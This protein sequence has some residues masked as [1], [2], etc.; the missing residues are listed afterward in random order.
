MQRWLDED[1]PTP[2]IPPSIKNEPTNEP[3]DE[4]DDED[5]DNRSAITANGGNGNGGGG[6]S[7]NEQ[8]NYEHLNDHQQHLPQ[9]KQISP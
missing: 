6:G 7:I 5:D 1:Q 4:D 3:M 8:P 9:I 2:S